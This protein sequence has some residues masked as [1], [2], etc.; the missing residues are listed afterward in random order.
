MKTILATALVALSVAAPAVAQTQLEQSIGAAPGQYTLAEQVRL[1]FNQGE[2]PSE[3]SSY[4]ANS[5]DSLRYA[6]MNAHNPA[7]QAIFDRLADET[8]GNF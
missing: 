5:D 3:R 2:A 4:L 8:S 6:T 7:A 1:K